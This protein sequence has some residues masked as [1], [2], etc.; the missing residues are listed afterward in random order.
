MARAAPGLDL[1]RL[2]VRLTPRGGRNLLEGW[3]TDAAGRP[4]LKAR[5]AAAPADGQANA[6]LIGLLAEALGRPKSAV[7]L[8]AGAGSRLKQLEISG[9]TE[10]ELVAKL[11]VGGR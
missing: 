5:V 9:V 11:G 8:A 10:A 1:A 3:T 6:A 4:V 7:R 2:T